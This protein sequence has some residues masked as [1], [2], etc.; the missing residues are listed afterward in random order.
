MSTALIILVTMTV[1]C[2]LAYILGA[3]MASGSDADDY[4]DGF[5]DGVRF[6]QFGGDQ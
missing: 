2:P 1:A 3:V 4:D 5:A 6:A